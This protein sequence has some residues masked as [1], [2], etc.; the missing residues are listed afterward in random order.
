MAHVSDIRIS[1]VTLG[2]RFADFRG[3]LASRRA[4]N[5]VYRNTYN[6]LASLTDREL[7]DIGISRSDIK[8]VASE[9]AYY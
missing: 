5:R 6:E 1:G 7:S 2:D 4:Q 3:A 9:A 8:R